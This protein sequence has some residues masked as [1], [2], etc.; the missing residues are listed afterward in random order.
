[1]INLPDV[2]PHPQRNLSAFIERPVHDRRKE[3]LRS[4]ARIREGVAGHQLVLPNSQTAASRHS[5]VASTAL[6]VIPVTCLHC[7]KLYPSRRLLRLHSIKSHPGLQ[8]M[9]AVSAPDTR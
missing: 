7:N 6:S 3:S 5:F 8:E 4:G 9:F 2:R 1:M